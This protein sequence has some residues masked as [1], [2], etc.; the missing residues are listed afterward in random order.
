LGRIGRWLEEAGR[1]GVWN[2][3]VFGDIGIKLSGGAV[4]KMARLEKIKFKGNEF[5]ILKVANRFSFLIYIL[6]AITET[7]TVRL[8]LNL[9]RHV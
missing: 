3:E 2:W 5:A 4:Y 1:V 9:K 6:L 7:K 8:N